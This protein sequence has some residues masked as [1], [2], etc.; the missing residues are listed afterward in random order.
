MVKKMTILL[1]MTYFAIVPLLFFLLP[2]QTRWIIAPMFIGGFE[3][4]YG[5]LS[6]VATE[7]VL[8][9]AVLLLFTQ[10]HPSTIILR[11]LLRG[12]SGMVV[13]AALLFFAAQGFF[14]AAKP[15]WIAA[16]LH[17]VE[18]AALITLT[19]AYP[20]KLLLV[21]AFIVSMLV[22]SGFAAAQTLQQSIPASTLLGMAAQDP[23]TLGV[24]VIETQTSRILR[25]YGGLPH[26][27]ILGGYLA[28][29]IFIAL[30]AYLE[31]Q[32][33]IAMAWQQ[34]SD[35]APA[36]CG[37]RERKLLAADIFF[38]SSFVL[39][40]FALALTF[41]RSAWLGLD[42]GIIG[43]AIGAARMRQAF[44]KIA[45][46]K[47]LICVGLGALTAIAF[48]P[49]AYVTRLTRGS[50]AEIR[51]LAERTELT[52]TA[53]HRVSQHP[54]RGVGLGQG[55]VAFIPETN[56]LPGWTYQPP[57]NVFLLILLEL[58]IM[59]TTLLCLLAAVILR[60]VRVPPFVLPYLALIGMIGLFDHYLWSLYPGV[61]LAC[62]GLGLTIVTGSLYY[63]SD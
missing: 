38:I 31:V 58:G 1:R 34:A 32:R 4:P 47:M 19:A 8:W 2:L 7:V 24:A 17:L 52:A 46:A 35:D 6:L 59:G 48:F 22:Q 43:V 51:S 62:A 15:L 16:L 61:L 44:P 11:K 13:A 26:P 54:V 21:S 45:F 63:E 23:Q 5:T 27:N 57:H 42:A 41:S 50:R 29:G 10:H 12:C 49:E 55:V 33:R 60:Y 18:G 53:L 40:A 9:L 56:T 28:I 14:A 30:L 36:E 25:A 39:L 37:I 3:V 20:R